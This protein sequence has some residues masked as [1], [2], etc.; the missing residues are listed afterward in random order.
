MTP[1]GGIPGCSLVPLQGGG[2]CGRG[3]ARHRRGFMNA[4]FDQIVSSYYEP[5]YRFAFNLARAEA[6]ACDLTQHTFH[7]W[8]AKGHELR[9]RTKVKAWLFTV[10]HRHFLRLCKRA[11]RFPHSELG[12]ASEEA[13]VVAPETGDRF[14]SALAVDCLARLQEPY[15][16]ALSLFYLEDYSYQEIADLLEVPIGTVRSRIFRGVAQL[17]EALLKGA[18]TPIRLAGEAQSAV[19]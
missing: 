11:S 6:D 3:R 1:L 10:L 12:A 4:D 19:I 7:M 2:M 16:S 18:R 14:D 8:A 13:S 15:R 17:R 5:L 9:D